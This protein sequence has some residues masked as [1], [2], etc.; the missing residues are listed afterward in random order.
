MA[1][2]SKEAIQKAVE[3]MGRK[4][5]NPIGQCF[6]TAI[7]QLLFAGDAPD[8]ARL[9]HGLGIANMPGQE[10]KVMAHAWVEYDH[11]GHGR[12]AMDTT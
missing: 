11:P 2:L 8:D 7:R 5:I 9:C 3:A 1:T 10:G 12:I 6:E 4:P